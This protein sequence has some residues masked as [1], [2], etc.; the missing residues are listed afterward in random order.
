MRI[1]PG[2]CAPDYALP[3]AYYLLLSTY[4]TLLTTFHSPGTTFHLLRTA[5]YYYLRLTTDHSPLTTYL[6]RCA[7]LTTYDLPEQVRLDPGT[8]ANYEQWQVRA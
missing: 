1:D 2:T 5:Y 4:Y 7:P 6:S 8:R 3:S